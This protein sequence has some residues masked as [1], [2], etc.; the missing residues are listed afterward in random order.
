MPHGGIWYEPY[1]HATIWVSYDNRRM[2]RIR[3]RLKAAEGRGVA[4]FD[5]V[6][7]AYLFLGGAGAG[8]CFVL[9][10][11][12]LLIPARYLVQ[13]TFHPT[14]FPFLRYDAT[15][16]RRDEAAISDSL[17]LLCAPGWRRFAPSRP[18]SRAP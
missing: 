12:G 5:T 13:T 8:I 10:I 16:Y 4:V 7:V 17:R 11:L 18:K 3:A 1:E 14:P 2:R 15:V 6:V 9:S